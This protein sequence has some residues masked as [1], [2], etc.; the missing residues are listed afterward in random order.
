MTATQDP[1]SAVVELVPDTLDGSLG[2]SIRTPTNI[3]EGSERAL[4]TEHRNVTLECRVVHLQHATLHGGPAALLCFEFHFIASALSSSRRI[5]SADIDS[6]FDSDAADARVHVVNYAPA[7]VEGPPTEVT[8]ERE[9]SLKPSVGLT[10]A[11]VPVQGGLE[12]GL[13]E[14]VTFVGRQA[15]RLQ[16]FAS[17]SDTR[18]ELHRARWQV[19]ENRA[20]KLGIPPIFRVAVLVRTG[21]QAPLLCSLRLEVFSGRR[22]L[23][24][25]PWSSERPL[26]MEPGASVGRALDVE[27][28]EAMQDRDWEQLLQVAY[29]VAVSQYQ[30]P[31]FRILT[32]G[33]CYSSPTISQMPG[34]R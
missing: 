7:L 2:P 33:R 1:Y 26:V 4:F 18:S 10:A 6:S 5:V 14:R 3:A 11:P 28:F 8:T 13:S 30:Q 29:P 34:R 21:E 27:G 22:R 12:M 32:A 15:L 25:M 23:L 16:G 20:T 17:S 9:K 31:V 24:G 19:K